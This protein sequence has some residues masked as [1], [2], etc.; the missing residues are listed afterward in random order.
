[1]ARPRKVLP[2]Y[3]SHPSGKARVVWTF[4]FGRREKM[5]PGGFN[6]PECLQGFARFQLEL[7]SSPEKPAP[8]A[9]GPTVVE[10]LAPYLRH[11]TG[12]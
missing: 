9:K 10:I 1:M 6:S 4:P 7:A 5:L 3:L 12:Y 8:S 11:A 2:R